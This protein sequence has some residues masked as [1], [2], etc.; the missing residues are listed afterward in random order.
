VLERKLSRIE[1]TEVFQ[2]FNKV[3]NRMGISGLPEDFDEWE[4][5]RQE[6]L[7]QNMQRSNYTDDLFSQYRKHLGAMRYRILLEAQKLVVPHKVRELL[8]LGKI[9]L[10]H[11][12]VVIY[13]I[14]RSVNVD[15]LLK[16]LILPSKYKKEIRALDNVRA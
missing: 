9:S 8:G 3:G 4:K 5:M 14:S 2:V 6:H 15:W 1:K 7:H 16:A 10:L 11:P 12:L 13:K